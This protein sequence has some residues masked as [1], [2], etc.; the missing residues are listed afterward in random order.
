V[1]ARQRLFEEGAMAD[2]F[3][4]IDAGQ[5]T[6]D[7]VVPGRGRLTI[8]VYG[9]GD[10]L[11]VGGLVPPHRC[12]VGAVASQPMQ[13]YQFDARAVRAACDED[14]ALGYELIR[15]VSGVL[16]GRLTAL[17]NRLLEASAHAGTSV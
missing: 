6:S 11:G 2:R 12:H 8:A 1:P 17:H 5:V 4:L 7:T 13:A 9:R 3:W 16:M 15:R 14:P 10:F